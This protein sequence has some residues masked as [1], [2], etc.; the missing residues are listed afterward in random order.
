[1]TEQEL[2]FCTQ[3]F[4]RSPD[5]RSKEGFGIGLT[6]AQK[7]LGF[8]NIHLVIEPV[9]GLGTKLTLS[10]PKTLQG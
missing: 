8:H 6:V 1:M 7:I 9:K 2:N 5:V 4:Y 3:P 10:F